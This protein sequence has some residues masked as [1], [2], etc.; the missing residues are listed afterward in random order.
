L[1]ADHRVVQGASTRALVLWMPALQARA[2]LQGRDF[3]SADDVYA[4]APYIF[5]HR[6]EV[7][8][9]VEDPAAVVV[10]CAKGPVEK[11]SRAVLRAR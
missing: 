1:R 4:L 10:E 8:S 3:V 5:G 6:I 9:G 7:I 2:L 11:L